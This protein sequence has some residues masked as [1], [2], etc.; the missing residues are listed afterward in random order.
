[1]KNLTPIETAYAY[2]EQGRVSS[3]RVTV[4]ADAKG[5][6]HR[7]PLTPSIHD[8]EPTGTPTP[9]TETAPAPKPASPAAPTE[10]AAPETA[11]QNP[12]N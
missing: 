6:L 8:M 5:D 11:P 4:M 2:D 7:V 1:M 12:P 10:P 3:T 9:P